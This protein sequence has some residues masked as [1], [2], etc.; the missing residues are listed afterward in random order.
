MN[1]KKAN[2]KK[3]SKMSREHWG[4]GRRQKE[5]CVVDATLLGLN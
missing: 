2:K 3:E 4:G 1:E 5:G